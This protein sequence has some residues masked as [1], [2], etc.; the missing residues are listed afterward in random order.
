MCREGPVT[1][2]Q[3][4]PADVSKV[5]APPSGSATGDR[6]CR[7]T[8]AASCTGRRA[9][10]TLPALPGGHLGSIFDRRERP[11]ARRPAPGERGGGDDDAAMRAVPTYQRSPGAPM[12][13]GTLTSVI[14]RTAALLIPVE[15]PITAARSWAKGIHQEETSAPA[16]SGCL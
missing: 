9:V 4:C 10:E 6:C 16:V 5:A 11:S 3:Y 14:K 8:T 1:M 15:E 13:E 2:C 12:R 7:S